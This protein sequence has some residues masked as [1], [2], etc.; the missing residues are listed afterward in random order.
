MTACALASSA[1]NLS[2]HSCTDLAPEC[3]YSTVTL[4][5]PNDAWAAG[6]YTLALS[7]DGVAGQCTIAIPD[8]PPATGVQGTCAPG[9]NAT[10]SLA[11][12]DSCP[13]VRCS[14]YACGGGSADLTCTHIP[15]RF[16]I[17]MVVQSLS[18]Q[19]GLD[20]SLDG[21]ELLKETIAPTPTTTEPNGS[22]CG[23]CTNGSATLSLGGG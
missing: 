19:L 14:A 1:C 21:R 13:P 9:S 8:P 7:I 11:T 18:A 16:Q 17:K 15:G 23:E 10:W 6:M 12:V 20:F 4:S 2:S 5:S 3:G 22:G